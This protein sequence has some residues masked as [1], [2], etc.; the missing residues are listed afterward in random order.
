MPC[1]ESHAPIGRIDAGEPVKPW[2]IST[3]IGPPSNENAS[4]PGRTR[5]SLTALRRSSGRALASSGIHE[6]RRDHVQEREPDGAGQPYE[7]QR[8]EPFEQSPGG[9]HGAMLPE[10]RRRSRLNPTRR[11]QGSRLGPGVTQDVV[12]KRDRAGGEVG[13]DATSANDVAPSSASSPLPGPS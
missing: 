1:D 2:T 4:Q 3:P 6:E 7:Q 11:A 13:D 5:G 10:R 9:K 12:P 8:E